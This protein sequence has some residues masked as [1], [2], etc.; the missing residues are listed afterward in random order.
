MSCI[1]AA[2]IRVVSD[3]SQAGHPNA[4]PANIIIFS[5]SDAL[6]IGLFYSATRVLR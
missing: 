6:N 2:S 1:T 5:T 4:L 3:A